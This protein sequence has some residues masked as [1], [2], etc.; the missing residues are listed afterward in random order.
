MEECDAL[1]LKT[2]TGNVCFLIPFFV[3]F[4]FFFCFFFFFFSVRFPLFFFHLFHFRKKKEERR[5]KAISTK[6]I[7]KKEWRKLQEKK[8]KENKRIIHKAK[9]NKSNFLFLILEKT[10][11]QYYTL[12]DSLIVVP[13]FSNCVIDNLIG[14]SSLEIWYSVLNDESKTKK[15]RE[16][17]KERRKR[18]S[19]FI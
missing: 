3:L 2:R 8:E 11:Y 1:R 16:R 18:I 19:L 17:H 4:F 14:L 5:R 10:L 6:Q 15:N 13:F 7:S 12:Q 9:R